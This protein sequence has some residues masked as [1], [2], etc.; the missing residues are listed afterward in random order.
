[1]SSQYPRKRPYQKTQNHNQR[2]KLEEDESIEDF[3]KR[4]RIH[5]NWKRRVIIHEDTKHILHQALILGY[6]N[7]PRR[8]GSRELSKKLEISTYKLN[9]EL[10]EISKQI[11]FEYFRD[12][13]QAKPVTESFSHS[14]V[15]ALD[16]IEVRQEASLENVCGGV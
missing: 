14:T 7:H 8:I 5:N 11:L 10:R 12:K 6:Y 3:A 2:L 1:M 13:L 4:Y 9:K 15:S 16:E